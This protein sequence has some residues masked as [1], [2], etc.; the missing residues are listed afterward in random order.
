MS[1]PATGKN[2]VI[3]LD[4]TGNQVRANGNTNVVCVFEMLD[5]SDPARQIAYYDPGVGTFSARGAWTPIARWFSRILG[6]AFGNGLRTNLAEAYTYLIEHWR[7]GDRV[8]IF[9]FSRGAYTARALAGLLHEPGLLRPGS[10]N[11]VQ[12]IVSAYTRKTTDWDELH[13]YTNAFCSKSADGRFSIPVEFLGVWDTVK[14]AGLLRWALHWPF[15]RQVPNVAKAFHAVSIDE[16][17]RPYREYLVLP[18]SERTVLT[19]TWFAGVHSDVGGTFVDDP[20]LARIALKWMADGALD[21]GVLLRAD[22]YRKNCALATADASGRVHDMGWIWAL[23][24]YRHRTVPPGARVHASVRARCETDSRYRRR[25]PADARWED[26][27]W[28]KPHL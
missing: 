27:Q 15:T 22:A 11:L 24:T 17:R 1:T 16:K 10:E 18:R 9:G 25:I 23:L 2:I 14:A 21:A 3:C 13:Q 8:F 28:T 26:E 19:E 4:G 12:Y 5:L 20:K 6:L 7:P